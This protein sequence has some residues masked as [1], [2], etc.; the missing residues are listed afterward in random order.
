MKSSLKGDSA[1]PT[2]GKQRGGI[3]ATA[4]YF[5]SDHYWV[6]RRAE[7]RLSSW[8]I[9]DST[10][11]QLEVVDGRVETAAAAVQAIRKCCEALQT[12]SFFGGEKTI[13][14]KNA[15]FLGSSSRV[16]SGRDVQNWMEKLVGILRK[17]LPT[18]VR[19]LATA[20]GV[21]KRTAFYKAME[22]LGEAVA[23]EV[24]EKSWEIERKAPLAIQRALQEMGLDTGPEVIETMVAMLGADTGRIRQEVQKLDLYVGKRRRITRDDI[25]AIVTCSR[26]GEAWDLA[27]AAAE[28][29]LDRALALLDNLL[30]QRVSPI[31][32]M[33][34][35]EGRFRELAFYREVLNRGW[36]G[37]GDW[38]ARRGA[39]SPLNDLPEDAKQAAR[40][41]LGRDPSEILPYVVGIRLRQAKRFTAEELTQAREVWLDA[42]RRLVTS[43]LNPQ[44]VLETALIRVLGQTPLSQV[45]SALP[46]SAVAEILPNV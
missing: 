29:Q 20:E 40:A 3:P 41:V 8:G 38:T 14:L 32:I 15:T 43:S 10:S 33:L 19:F 12:P 17:G 1:N 46:H 4:L 11:L 36:L 18:G 24:P 44:W 6:N 26:G 16:G 28:R 45:C 31:W 42:H 37:K 23:F 25:F 5:G 27:D 2:G 34:V 35:L 39:E 7:E 21:E 13:W 9:T 22:K 30:A